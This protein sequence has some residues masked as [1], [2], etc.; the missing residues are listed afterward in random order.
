MK[1]NAPNALADCRPND[2]PIMDED[3]AHLRDIAALKQLNA[4]MLA[5]LENSVSSME[6]SGVS[7]NATALKM[8]RTAL[9][10]AKGG[11]A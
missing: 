10:K 6:E 9:A 7:A 4:E 5:A 3:D 1:L 2:K 8:A 11:K